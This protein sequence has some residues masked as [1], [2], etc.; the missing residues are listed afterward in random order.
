[1]GQEDR[2]ACGGEVKRV[3]ADGGCRKITCLYFRFEISKT[4]FT[5]DAENAR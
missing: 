2:Q 4:G 1:M 5:A 3:E